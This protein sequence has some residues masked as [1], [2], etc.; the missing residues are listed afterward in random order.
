MK[1]KK[2]TATIYYTVDR[3]HPDRKYMENQSTKIVR[4][5]T[6]TYLFDIYNPRSMMYG[7]TKE[8]M[9]SCMKSDLRLVAGGGYDSKHI[10]NVRFEF[11]EG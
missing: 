10:H 5:Y 1:M 4:T 7:A 6:N 9:E 11:V 2:I 3:N 8:Q